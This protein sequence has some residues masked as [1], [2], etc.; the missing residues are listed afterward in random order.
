M[1]L[2]PGAQDIL[3]YLEKLNIPTTIITNECRYTADRLSQ[4]L[5]ELGLNL[6]KSTGIYTSAIATADFILNRVLTYPKTLVAVG[7]VGEEGLRKEILSVQKHNCKV[8]TEPPQMDSSKDI[9][10][11]LVIGSLNFI[12]SDV[13]SRCEK[14]LRA[15]AKV[16]TTCPD[17]YDPGYSGYYFI[18]PDKLLH[19][20]NYQSV[21]IQPYSP[22]K[23]NINIGHYIRNYFKRSHLNNILFVGDTLATDIMLAND[24][25]IPSCF[26]LSSQY[27]IK[28]LN[29]HIAKPTY[30]CKNLLKLKKL[31]EIL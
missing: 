19:M 1:K 12:T 5:K 26:M 9:E 28:S 15:G 8:F 14:W 4:N 20:L 10:Y 2:K 18:N 31:F 17:I 6:P 29:Y 13:L 30:I 11:L 23:P 7:V 16:I 22:G 27:A 3:N 24:L 25:N 21:P